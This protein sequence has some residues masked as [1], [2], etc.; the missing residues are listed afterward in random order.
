MGSLRPKPKGAGFG[1]MAEKMTK[2]NSR[3]KTKY[4]SLWQLYALGYDAVMLQLLPYRQLMEE[5]KRALAPEK[6]WHILDA[7]CGTGNFLFHLLQDCP[8]I[9]ARGVD[10]SAAMLNRARKKMEKDSLKDKELLFQE[11]NLNEGLPFRDEEFDGAI[12]V[13]VLYAVNKPEFLLEEIYRVLRK[14][15]RLILVTP[16]FQP[17]MGAVFKEHL[18]ILKQK[19]QSLWLLKLCW[20]ILSLLPFLIIFLLANCFIKSS[21][22]FH[23]LTEEQ[24]SSLAKKCGFNV[25]SIKAVYGGQDWL[26]EAEKSASDCNR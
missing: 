2:L 20:Q 26:L 19:E 22:A 16:P 5:V 7:G 11:G 4:K 6:N 17:R 9:K 24:L 25:V 3:G 18:S 8:G 1:K 21:K 23:F 14:K 15:G 12:C 13:N 10:Y